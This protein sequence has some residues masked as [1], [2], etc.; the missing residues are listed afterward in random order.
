ME[1]RKELSKD[2][3]I[4]QVLASH[5]SAVFNWDVVHLVLNWCVVVIIL[6]TPNFTEHHI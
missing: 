5:K 3:P 1:A 2:L 4:K 6:S